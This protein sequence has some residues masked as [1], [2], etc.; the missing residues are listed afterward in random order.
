MNQ[1]AKTMLPRTRMSVHALKEKRTR[2]SLQKLASTKVCL[3]CTGWLLSCI[4]HS[5]TRSTHVDQHAIRLQAPR[6]QAWG[7]PR[8]AMHPPAH[9]PEI[10]PLMRHNGTKR[11]PAHATIKARRHG[12]S[13]DALR[14]MV[15]RSSRWAHNR[16]RR[17][18][19]QMWNA[20]VM[21]A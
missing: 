12:V 17:T 2:P 1:S 15:L 7:W 6:G 3:L 8:C 19:T 16:V 5:H 11:R 9:L 21:M 4:V 20:E 14:A 13:C 10:S 18:L